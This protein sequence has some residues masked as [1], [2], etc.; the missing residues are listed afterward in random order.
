[1]SAEETIVDKVVY[2][3]NGTMGRLA[4][5]KVRDSCSHLCYETELEEYCRRDDIDAETLIGYTENNL[6]IDDPKRR[7]L[8]RE[9]EF[10][11]GKKLKNSQKTMPN[12]KDKIIDLDEQKIIDESEPPE[13]VINGGY[14]PLNER[15]IE[16][17]YGQTLDEYETARIDIAYRPAFYYEQQFKYRE[18]TEEEII[19]LKEQIRML[20]SSRDRYK[21]KYYDLMEKCDHTIL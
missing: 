1:M 18:E 10:K 3:P 5:V 14:Q 12:T 16:T 21:E 11:L 4:I 2:R 20:R 9:I 13:S 19:E 15:Q 17:K 8:I 6:H 7:N